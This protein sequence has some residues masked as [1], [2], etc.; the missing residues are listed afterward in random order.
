MKIKKLYGLLFTLL[1]LIMNSGVVAIANKK[2]DLNIMSSGLNRVEEIY[3]EDKSNSEKIKTLK[4][5]NENI[6]SKIQNPL[7]PFG[8]ITGKPTEAQLKK[9]LDSFRDVGI[10]QFLIYPRSG[11]ELEYMSEEWLDVCEY[12]IEY[13]EEYGMAIWLYDEFNWP[14]GSCKGQVIKQNEDFAAKKIAVYKDP[15]N[16]GKDNYYWSVSSVPLY[17]DVL[18]PKAVDTFISLTHE[19]Y[20]ER[21]KK[22]FGTVIK[23]IFTDEPSPMYAARRKTA[24]SLI[25]MTYWSELEEE[26]YQ[27]SNRDFRKDVE[28]HLNGSTPPN[29]WQDYFYLMGEKFKNSFFDKIKNWCDQHNILFTGHLMNEFLP[30]FALLANGDPMEMINSFSLTGIDEIFTRTTLN[31]VEWVTMKMVE[32]AANQLGN[33]A[34]AELFALGPPDMTLGKRRQMI[35]I[36]ALHGCDHYLLAISAMD[37]RAN[38]EEKPAYYN[39][40]TTTQPWFNALMDLGEDAKKAALIARKKMD[41]P[42]IAVRY[43]Q[44]LTASTIFSLTDNKTS[45]TLPQLLKNLVSWQWPHQLIDEKSSQISEYEAILSFSTQGII[46]EKT[47]IEFNSLEELL[48]WLENNIQRK[49]LIENSKGEIINDVL[50]KAYADGCVCVVSLSDSTHQGPLILKQP[51]KQKAFFELP[52]CGV[53]IYE[54]GQ[55]YFYE[56]VENVIEISTEELLPYKLSS[57][58]VKRIKFDETGKY[59]F[60]IDD[61]LDEISIAVRNY[62]DEVRVELDEQ[63]L[64]NNE[65]CQFLPDGLKELYF[66]SDKFSLKNRRHTLKLKSDIRDARFLP[67][68]FIGGK[69]AEKSKDVLGILPNALSIGEFREQGLQNYI[70]AITFTKKIKMNKQEYLSVD[71]NGLVTEIYMGKT[72]DVKIMIWTSV[73]PLFE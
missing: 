53:F 49:L 62:G 50:V 68:A 45:I 41:N 31:S 36:T 71:T 64:T 2:T 8:S 25:E 46:E 27:H 60:I 11:L 16:L 22:Y 56:R 52:E 34:Y 73:G 72:V 1:F 19:K 37:S 42:L 57:P 10:E 18:N 48:L 20:Y 21:F 14:S 40:H 30:S 4:K 55:S 17:A 47:G 33:G 35:W 13:A 5:Q 28:A 65:I 6:L 58:N 12:I 63:S 32:N 70:G 24:G 3:P 29:L 69:F 51:G 67:T 61:L 59:E 26:Y 39:P 44:K 66:E 38:F 9:Y 43:P 7:I 15:V 54:P 23:G